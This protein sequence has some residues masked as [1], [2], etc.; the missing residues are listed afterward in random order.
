MTRGPNQNPNQNPASAS[1]R[2]GGVSF[3]MAFFC[4]VIPILLYSPS[5]RGPFVFDDFSNIVDNRDIRSP[6]R[7]GIGLLNTHLIVKNRQAPTRPVTSLTFALNYVWNGLN[8]FG[9]RLF[10]ILVHSANTL[11]VFLMTLMILR[12]LQD[13]AVKESLAFAIA[14]IFC[15]HPLQTEAVAYISHRSDS[16]ATFFYLLSMLSFFAGRDRR[17]PYSVLPAAFFFILAAGSKEWTYAALP[18]AL[19]LIDVLVFSRSEKLR[20]WRHAPI[21]ILAVILI[22]SRKYLTGR[23]GFLGPDLDRI[24][25]ALT[26]AGVQS[27]VWLKYAALWFLPLWQTFD[28]Y[29]VPNAPGLARKIFA[30]AA[31]WSAAIVGAGYWIHKLGWKEFSVRAAQSASD[32]RRRL[33][34][35]GLGMAAILIAP[36]SSIIPTYEAMAERRVY[37]AVWSG[38]LAWVAFLAGLIKNGGTLK[39]ALAVHIMLLAALTWRRTELYRYPE[40]LWEE[41]IERY[42][43]N[44]D[45]HLNLGVVEMKNGRPDKALHNWLHAVEL[46]KLRNPQAFNNIGE[47]YFQRGEIRKALEYFKEAA[48]QD[49]QLHYAWRNMGDAFYELG[50]DAAAEESYHRAL[51]LVPDE[52][53]LYNNLG[54]VLERRKNFPGA[55][56]AYQKAMELDPD[57][58]PAHAHLAELYVQTERLPEALRRYAQWQVLEPDNPEIP[59][60]I[61]LLRRWM[62]DRARGKK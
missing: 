43:E 55:E 39:A 44:A 52:P 3:L 56:K 38:S 26:Y 16:M 40:K 14:L 48:R 10:N 2:A 5:L 17:W 45:A 60:K 7:I 25:P 30:S 46:R 61:A 1:G 35:L 37:L 15:V 41:A 36:T 32:P 9:Y 12:R 21:W 27:Y 42:P 31:L 33:L 24:W 47:I 11:L 58:A 34:W 18:A 28:H 19:L 22:A 57:F 4:L 29:L 6:D 20:M 53:E 54:L 23:W 50:E 8:P 51:A 49:P 59:S 13:A 62:S